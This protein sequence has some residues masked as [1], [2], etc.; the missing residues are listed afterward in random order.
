MKDYS[1][2]T[3]QV[4]AKD[5]PLTLKARRVDGFFIPTNLFNWPFCDAY[6]LSI[7]PSDKAPI[8]HFPSGLESHNSGIDDH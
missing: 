6:L 5:C 2:K 7:A 1:G 3:I 4:K 8:R